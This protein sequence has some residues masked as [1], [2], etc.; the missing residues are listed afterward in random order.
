M[1]LN[2]L[3]T[4]SMTLTEHL[5]VSFW[6]QLLHFF[7]FCMYICA[8]NSGKSQIWMDSST[9]FHDPCLSTLKRKALSRQCWCKSV[10]RKYIARALH[11]FNLSMHHT[12]LS[13]YF[14][15]NNSWGF[16]L[17][18]CYFYEFTRVQ[19]SVSL[20]S[21]FRCEYFIIIEAYCVHWTFILSDV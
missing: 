3:L 10:I 1:C 21:V 5:L 20:N 16:F 11:I 6:K 9:L 18:C 17:G 7:M 8:V 4:V 19:K 15:A 14:P 2:I 12:P 13:S